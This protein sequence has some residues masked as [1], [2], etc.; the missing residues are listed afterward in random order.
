MKEI[1]KI[2][3]VFSFDELSDEAREKACQQIG[4]SMTEDDGWWYEG[5]FEMFV[6]HCREYGMEVDVND[7]SF[8]GFGSQGDG[9]SF[10]CDSI[11]TSSLLHALDMQVNNEEK[12]LKYVYDVSII[13][14]FFQASHEQTVHA[15]L[16]VDADTLVEEED[17]EGIQYIQDVADT[18][19]FK[20]EALKD[21]LCQRLYYDLEREYDYL[22]SAE[23]ADELAYGNGMLFLEDGAVYSWGK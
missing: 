16:C 5:I 22:Y 2:T 18:L 23:F 17:D 21:A 10:V 14:T 20:L 15:R 11:D 4:D 7:I 1:T 3:K 13:R 6:D 9:A 8:S 19:E 12:V